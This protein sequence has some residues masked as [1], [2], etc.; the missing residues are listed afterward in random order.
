ML[1]LLSIDG[2]PFNFLFHMWLYAVTPALRQLSYASNTAL[3]MIRPFRCEQA[4]TWPS[5][6]VVVAE[7]YSCTSA[8]Q[9]ASNARSV[10]LSI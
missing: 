1:R 5:W 3:K 6:Y 10:T 9:Q 4:Q 7:R 2:N 8:E